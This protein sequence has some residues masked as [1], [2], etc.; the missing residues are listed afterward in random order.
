MFGFSPFIYLGG[1][2]AGMS[3]EESFG[4]YLI[5]STAAMAAIIALRDYD[6]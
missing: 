1:L 4:I 2:L 5:V 3:V 6:D